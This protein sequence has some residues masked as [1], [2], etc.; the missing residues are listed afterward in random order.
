MQNMRTTKRTIL[1]VIFILSVIV[2]VS[3]LANWLKLIYEFKNNIVEFTIPSELNIELENGSCDLFVMSSKSNKNADDDYFKSKDF[4]NQIVI[5]T[6]EGASIK[7]RKKDA[8][9]SCKLL[10]KEYKR[11]GSFDLDTKQI[12]RIESN[13]KDVF[14]EKFAYAKEGTFLKI[15]DIMKFGLFFI[16]SMGGV[17]IS[18]ISLLILRKNTRA[19]V[20]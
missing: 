19:I 9:M 7:I 14:I 5:K 13:S 3:L 12:V 10:D 11:I 8:N 16:L 1:S 17:L 18:G 6:K 20:S 4:L 15:L 2:G